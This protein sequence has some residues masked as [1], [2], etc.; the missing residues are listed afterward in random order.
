[1]A[2]VIE[3]V[4]GTWVDGLADEVA[5]EIQSLC[6]L[7]DSRMAEAVISLD[8]FEDGAEQSKASW[9]FVGTRTGSYTG[10]VPLEYVRRVPF[11]YARTFVTTLAQIARALR[12]LAALETADAKA[13]IK[14]AADSVEKA[15][16]ELRPIRDSAEHAEDRVRGRGKANK[17]LPRVPLNNPIVQAPAGGLIADS[18]N[19]RYYGWTIEDGSYAE[20]E[21]SDATLEVARTAVQRVYD[22]LRW[23]DPGEHRSPG[24]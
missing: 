10:E 8:L 18:L 9:E 1:M 12:K 3:L 19:G 21:V 2:R 7:L 23:H 24:R 6:D 20:V 15:L 4:R 5:S 14:A 17:P 11:L 16:P 13:E 22:A